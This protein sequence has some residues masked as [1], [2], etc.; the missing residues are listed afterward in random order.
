MGRGILLL[1]VVLTGCATPSQ[2]PYQPLA[3]NGGFTEQRLEANRFRVTFVGNSITTR[4]EVENALLFRIAELTLHEGFDYFVLSDKDTEANTLYLQT[5]TGYDTFDP[6]YPR[7]WPRTTFAS[8]MATPITNY[9]GQANV[10]MF[11]GTKP[12]SDLNAYDARQVQ[13]S[14]A[15]LIRRPGPP[16]P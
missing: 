2:T 3:D 9:K 13:T 14:L 1:L 4:E 8:G 10:V 16:A 6:F 7:F 5:L 15:P 11:K 12:E